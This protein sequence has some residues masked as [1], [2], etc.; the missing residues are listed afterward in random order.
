MGTQHMEDLQPKQSSCPWKAESG[1]EEKVWGIQKD[2]LK[3]GRKK[4]SRVQV[5]I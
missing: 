3:R 5:L 2:V 4:N 1:K